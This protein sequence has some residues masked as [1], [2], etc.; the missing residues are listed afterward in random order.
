MKLTFIKRIMA[1]MA[2][3]FIANI[4][5]A[6]SSPV[7]MLQA[8]ANKIIAELKKN[9]ADLRSNPRISYRIVTNYLV[10]L[11]DKDAM[12]Q[13]VLG[14]NAWRK[15]TDVQRK[16]FIIQFQILV[17][18]TYASA[19]A[20]FTNETVK[21]MPQR[22]SAR[23][24]TMVKSKIIRQG[25]PAINVNYRLTREGSNWK[26]VDFSVDGISLVESFKSQFSSIYAQ[27]GMSGL[28]ASLKQHNQKNS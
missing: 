13:Q 27:R 23:S 11:V 25:R 9:K 5:L 3:L 21:F 1:A 24:L 20:Q 4:A 8:T 14:R 26:I 22:N 19:I 10:P 15:A 16:E 17:V 6:A 12:A 18:R 2:L 7:P 28:L